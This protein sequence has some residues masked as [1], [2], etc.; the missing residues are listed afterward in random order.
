MAASHPLASQGS[1]KETF[2][3]NTLWVVLGLVRLRSVGPK[4]GGLFAE[5]KGVTLDCEE[6]SFIKKSN[7]I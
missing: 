2:L 1:K 6:A 4:E 7:Y 5:F 3:K